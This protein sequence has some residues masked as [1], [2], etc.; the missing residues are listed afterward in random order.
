M[1]DHCTFVPALGF[2]LSASCAFLYYFIR[3]KDSFAGSVISRLLTGLSICSGSNDMSSRVKTLSR[4][5]NIP[6][7]IMDGLRAAILRPDKK[8]HDSSIKL[9]Q[10]SDRCTNGIYSC[11][12]T[13]VE[14]HF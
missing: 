10:Y 4:P 3:G 9:L 6:V 12:A 8:A 2:T 14:M 13:K 5:Q 7:W 11:D 1:C